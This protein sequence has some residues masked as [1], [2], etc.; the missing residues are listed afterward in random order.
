MVIISDITAARANITAADSC[1]HEYGD[2]VD[3]TQPGWRLYRPR[4]HCLNINQQQVCL[5]P[6]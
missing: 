4:D 6:N 3:K 5:W 1:C 2:E